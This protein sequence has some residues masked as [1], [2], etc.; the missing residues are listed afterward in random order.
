MTNGWQ[1]WDGKE[2]E[3]VN[4]V[5]PVRNKLVRCV[6]VENKAIFF[7]GPS[8]TNVYLSMVIKKLCYQSRWDRLLIW[9]KIRK[10]QRFEK[11]LAWKPE[12]DETR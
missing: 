10:D 11:V 4:D 7:D 6:Q 8:G 3:W 1:Y 5:V 12:G 2:K 9:L